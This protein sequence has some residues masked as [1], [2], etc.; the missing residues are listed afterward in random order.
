[1]SAI[2]RI[3]GWY[4]RQCDGE[5][6]HHQGISIQSCDNPGWWVKIE[7]KGTALESI[8]FNRTAEN[9]DAQGFQQGP[10]WLHCKVADGV[11]DGAGDETR[12]EQILELFLK[13][14]ESHNS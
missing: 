14:A 6:E 3:A 1:M 10:R 13:W 12:L 4:I 9:V 7:L 8:A 11:W 5:W 2:E